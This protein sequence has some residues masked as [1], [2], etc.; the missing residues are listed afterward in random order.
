MLVVED[1][2]HAAERGACALA[3]IAGHAS[4]FAA[5][6]S[7]PDDRAGWDRSAEALAAAIR[8]ALTDAELRPEQVDAIFADGMGVRSADAAEVAGLRTVFGDRTPRI[9]LTT[10]KAG[11]GRAYSGAAA[12][13]A[14]AAVLALRD[15]VVP[16]TPGVRASDV[17]HDVDLVTGTS[18]TLPLRHVLVLARGYGGFTSALVLSSTE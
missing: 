12:L 2:R 8:F 5:Q 1:S 9:P 4:T 10:V 16:P 3:R 11:I 17:D 6:P 15:G 13:E 18:R 14:A 7:G